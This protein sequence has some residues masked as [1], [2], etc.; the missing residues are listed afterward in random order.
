M[1]PLLPPLSPLPGFTLLCAHL[2]TS[3]KTDLPVKWS[4]DTEHS[5][6]APGYDGTSY[7]SL[8]QPF[9]CGKGQ[10]KVRHQCGNAF[11][12]L[13]FLECL[14]CA[15]HSPRWWD[16]DLPSSWSWHLSG[17]RKKINKKCNHN[18]GKQYKIIEGEWY[19]GKEKEE[20]EQ[21]KEAGNAGMKTLLWF[22]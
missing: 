6:W 1:S 7:F 20:T 4:S 5:S 12:P 2:L 22:E 18:I 3:V 17:E 15:R 10:K 19:Y 8:C 21:S 14:P 13:T 11:I 9:S 16:T